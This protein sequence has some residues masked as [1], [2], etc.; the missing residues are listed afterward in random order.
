[1]VKFLSCGKWNKY[2][3]YILL[4]AIFDVS[5]DCL[6]SLAYNNSFIGFYSHKND[7]FQDELAKHQTIHDLFNYVM[8]IILGFIFYKSEVITIKRDFS[9]KQFEKDNNSSKMILI[10]NSEKDEE[11]K[12]RDKPGIGLFFILIIWI[13]MEHLFSLYNS[14]LKDLDFWMIEIIILSFIMY[15]MFN[16]QIFRHHIIAMAINLIPLLLKIIS[17]YLTYADDSSGD[18]PIY[19]YFSNINISIYLIFGCGIF[20]YL[21]LILSKSYTNS[22]MKWFMDL[23][24]ISSNKILIYYG[25]LGTIILLSITI[26]STYHQCS[27]V[28][29]EN[30]PSQISFWDSI[31]KIIDN[32]GQK[33]YF[34]NFK[35][36]IKELKEEKIK[37][38]LLTSALCSAAFFFN[39]FFS[40]LVI[41]NLT[42]VHLTF[43]VPII[44]IIQ[45]SIIILHAIFYPG[46][47]FF[48]SAS[49][50]EFK[51]FF[52]DI[53]SDFFSA[54]SFLLYLEIIVL[55][56]WE[57]DYNI[58]ENIIKRGSLESNQTG[59]GDKSINDSADT[60]IEND[61]INDN[62][63]TNNYE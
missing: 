31:C 55:K 26:I 16:F 9:K 4:L 46:E 28:S 63:T 60:Q 24:N 58:K 12:E 27:E 15:K 21:I 54:F 22:K 49:E 23:K 40:I 50:I 20:S 33:K 2:Y 48:T 51:K 56:I 13:I 36:Y 37:K 17:I 14:I 25:I 30:D 10:Y 11:N 1:M 38:E 62:D 32:D 53:I 39:K 19:K 57:I 42:P 29:S 34:E 47:N 45:K 18:L 3:V 8:T 7:I 59:K 6:Y 61:S 35:L 44:Y 52:L 41:K 43:S 5:K